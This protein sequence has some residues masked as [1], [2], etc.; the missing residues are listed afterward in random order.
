LRLAHPA[1]R[2]M[3]RTATCGDDGIDT[4]NLHKRNVNRTL[5]LFD[6]QRVVAS[7]PLAIRW[8]SAGRR[9]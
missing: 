3:V 8:Q 5:A 6:G 4:G 1:L 7:H 9:R 2:T